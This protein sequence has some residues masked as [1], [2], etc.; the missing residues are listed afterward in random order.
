VEGIDPRALLLL[1]AVSE[2]DTAEDEEEAESENGA[3]TSSRST[4]PPM[5]RVFV[6]QRNV[7]RVAGTVDAIIQELKAALT[8]ELQSAQDPSASVE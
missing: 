7:E 4:P 1:D 6:Y 5:A 2:A 3:P 8:R